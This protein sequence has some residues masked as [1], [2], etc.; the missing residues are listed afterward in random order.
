MSLNRND[1]KTEI[2]RLLELGTITDDQAN[3]IFDK[4]YENQQNNSDVM[5][6]I[7]DTAAEWVQQKITELGF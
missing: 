4:S 6:N 5:L 7:S 3:Q 1:V 2:Y